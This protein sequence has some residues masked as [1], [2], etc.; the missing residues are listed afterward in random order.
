M[1]YRGQDN[2]HS[3]LPQ[4]DYEH[5]GRPNPCKPAP[6]QISPPFMP[7]LPGKKIG[8]MVVVIV[9][10]IRNTYLTHRA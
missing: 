10:K 2:G 9:P 4:R 5:A 6:G 1:A 7:P 3:L 8:K